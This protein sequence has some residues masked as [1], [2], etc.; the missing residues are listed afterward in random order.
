MAGY[1]AKELSGRGVL[2]VSGMAR[3]IDG[4]SHRGAL[5]A[6]AP[7]AGVLGCGID[8]I[9]PKVIKNSSP[10]WRNRG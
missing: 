7:T 10:M 6:G 4:A 5:D 9:Y 2:I 8:R 1:F 3:G